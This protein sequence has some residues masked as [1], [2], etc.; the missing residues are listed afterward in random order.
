MRL[1]KNTSTDTFFNMAA[2]EYFLTTVTEPLVM[3][4]RNARTVVIGRNQNAL[5]EVNA[6][7]V[8]QNN[9]DVVRRLT[10]G[11]AVFHDLG[12]INFT[13]I[14]RHEA[15]LYQN[16]EY[17]TAPVCEY[18]QSLNVNACF[19]GRNDL[20][21]EGRK[22]SGNAQVVL[23][24]NIMHHGTIMFNANV[25]ELV[26]ALKPNPLKISSK[27][28]KSVQARV[29]NVAEHLATSLSADEFYEQL[30]DAFAERGYKLTSVSPEEQQ[31]INNLADSKYR[32]WDWNFGRAPNYSLTKEKLFDFGIVQVQL[33]I[34]KGLIVD[35]K[36]Y[37]DFFGILDI[38]ELTTKLRGV[39]YNREGVCQALQDVLLGEYISGMSKQQLVDLLME[40]VE[41]GQ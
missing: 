3:L 35:I 36:I 34:S 5:Q 7:F 2:E 18:L 31:Q 20:L 17:F 27:S 39:R 6:D 15:G 24:K 14:Q 13:V 8:K 40:E 37:G 41:H 21:I 23:G 12:N 11:G 4:W 25:S 38:R 28:I 29:T 32:T 16:Y 30:L 33:D 19:A 9:I 10:G 26:G 1:I 22:F